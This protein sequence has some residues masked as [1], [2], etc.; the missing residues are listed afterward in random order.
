M[1]SPFALDPLARTAATTTVARAQTAQAQTAQ[2]AAGAATGAPK[3]KAEAFRQFESFVLQSFIQDMLPKNAEN[4]FGKGTAGEIWK[5]MLAEKLA[6]QI[7]AGGGIGIARQLAARDALA[8][9]TPPAAPTPAAAAPAAAA[10]TK[11]NS[12]RS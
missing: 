3:R 8:A 9:T 5:S 10:A 11:A 4:V 1:A 12:D 2:A 6:G 7:S